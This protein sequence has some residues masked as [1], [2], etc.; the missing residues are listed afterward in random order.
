MTLKPDLALIEKAIDQLEHREV[1]VLVWG[2]V[3]S[4]LSQE[5]VDET[6]RNVLNENQDLAADSDCTLD[7]E[8]SFRQRLLN[9]GYLIQVLGR[10]LAATRYR[11]RLAEGV[12]L[13]ARLR[14]LFPGKHEGAGW[15][16]GA[17]LVADYRL[18]WRPRKYPA[19]N[20]TRDDAYEAIAARISDPRL[21]AAVNHWFDEGDKN[22]RFARFQIDASARILDGLSMRS[23]RGTLVA[24]GTGSGK[25]IAFYLPALAWLSAER[26]AQSRSRGVRVLALY[27]RNELLKDQLAE[28]YAQARKFDEELGRVGTTL[29]VGVLFGDTPTTVRQIG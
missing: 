2:L 19:R 14:Q 5:E 17:T 22:W 10:P 27:P 4:A 28:V 8:A 13:F 24:A 20:L 29:S 15:V 23:P 18:L 25:T 12:R 6:L 26:K 21:L 9:L 16:S 3:D 1:R 7:T 11:T